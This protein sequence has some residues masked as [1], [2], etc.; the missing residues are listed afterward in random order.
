[1]S[2][3][4]S[5]R[6]FPVACTGRSARAVLLQPSQPWLTFHAGPSLSS[7]ASSKE[8]L[9]KLR[10]KTGYSFV[11]CK[12]ALETCGGDLK[13]AEDWLHKQAQ[14]EGWSK[15]A[16]LHGRKTKEGLIG[17]LQEGN[18][19]VLVEVVL[20]LSPQ[21]KDVVGVERGSR[22]R[23]L[24]CFGVGFVVPVDLEEPYWRVRLLVSLPGSPALKSRVQ[25]FRVLRELAAMNVRWT[26]YHLCPSGSP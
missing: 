13:Q 1:M 6:F 12:K 17:L 19:A 10:R 5:L 24:H 11:N 2:L 26:V 3:L 22:G 8:L 21:Q 25:T 16:K 14:K 4:R 9:M 15:A 20:C 23:D 18:T 7:A